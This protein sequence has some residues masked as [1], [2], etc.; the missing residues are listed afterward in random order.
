MCTASVHEVFKIVSNIYDGKIAP[1]LH[2]NNTSVTRGN[3]FKLHNRTFTQNFRNYVF[4]ARI[5]NI[6]NSLRS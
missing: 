3:K 5:V 2:Y 1:T 6:W 4:S